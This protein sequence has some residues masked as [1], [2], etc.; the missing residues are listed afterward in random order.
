MGIQS[1]QNDIIHDNG[2]H[3]DEVID[4][5]IVPNPV[6]NH[7]GDNEEKVND[8]IVPS[9]VYNDDD[10]DDALALLSKFDD[11]PD[12]PDHTVSKRDIG[13]NDGSDNDNDDDDGD[14]N[15]GDIEREPDDEE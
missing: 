11:L 8:D 3:D 13:N 1:P 10:G 4:G 14:E 7:D 2:Y 15:G 5:H 12:V 9:A 6:L